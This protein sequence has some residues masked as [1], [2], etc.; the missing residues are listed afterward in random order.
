MFPD[1]RQLVADFLGGD[2]RAF[3]QLVRRYL[4]PL[5][6]FIFQLTRDRNVAEDLT[7]ETFI[8]AWKHGARFDQKKS[9]KTWIFTIAKNTTYDFF[10]KKKSI[11][12]SFFEDDEGRNTLDMIDEDRPLPDEILEKTEK[13][14]ALEKALAKV[15]ELYRALLLLAYREDFSLG[16]I[17]EIL[18][19]PYNTIKSRHQRALKLLK[20]AF[21]DSDASAPE[22]ETY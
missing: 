20:R 11:P 16:E 5:Y 10:K 12:F 14:E 19:E 6:N 21:L 1:D 8:K 4:S 15:P 2:D 17:A 7:Q 13:I 9:F 18:G 3:E 22:Q